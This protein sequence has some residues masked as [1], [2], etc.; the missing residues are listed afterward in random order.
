MRLF[1]QQSGNQQRNAAQKNLRCRQLVTRQ[2]DRP[3]LGQNRAEGEQ[4]L[5]SMRLEET[6]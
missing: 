2:R 6:S 5:P 3:A 4:Q 1:E